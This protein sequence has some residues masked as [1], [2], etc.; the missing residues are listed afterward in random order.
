MDWLQY[1]VFI[2]GLSNATKKGN[3]FGPA[4]FLKAHN[5]LLLCDWTHLF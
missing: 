5:F 3:I 4:V 2:V 1:S